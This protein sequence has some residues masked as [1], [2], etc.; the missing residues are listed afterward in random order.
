MIRATSEEYRELHQERLALFGGS[1][2]LISI[3]F[4]V[5]SNLASFLDPAHTFAKWFT[6][7]G[8][9]Y[10]LAQAAVLFSL[11]V[12]SRYRP[13][14]QAALHALD[15]GSLFLVSVFHGLIG[16]AW[17]PEEQYKH[18]LSAPDVPNTMPI[19]T[20]T[21]VIAI[22]RAILVPSTARRTLGVTALASVP[23]IAVSYALNTKASTSTATVLLLTSGAV[24]WTLSGT[25]VAAIASHVVYHLRQQVKNAEKLGQYTL[26]AK[27]GEGA[28]GI[29]YR[30]SHA[31]LRRPTAIKLLPPDRAGEHN[32]ARFE[33]EVQLTSMLT[34]PN[35]IAIYDYGRTPDGIFYYAM[36]YLEGIDLEEL[37]RRH[38]PQPPGRVLRILTQ[39]AG[40]LAEAHGIGLI[41][42]DVKPANIF[43]CERGGVPDVAKIFDFGLVK[44]LSSGGDTKMSAANVLAGTP[45][46]LAPEA[47][48][49]PQ[50]VDARIDLYSLGCVGYFLLTGRPV[51]EGRTLLEICS[52][53]LHEKPVPP[54]ER[55]RGI[56]AKLERVILACLEK[57][58]ARR[59][60]DARAL[61][62]QLTAC[63]DVEAWSEESARR[64]WSDWAPMPAQAEVESSLRVTGHLW[65][66][67]SVPSGELGPVSESVVRPGA[68]KPFPRVAR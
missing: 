65:T 49:T 29:V 4:W 50:T 32:I 21:I 16:L 68:L 55:R 52:R 8:N 66:R 30:A 60:K 13:L 42:R 56:P 5:L 47:I 57:D 15:A 54:S 24:I 25:A 46:Y 53:H 18:G 22:T 6:L 43:L 59:P 41:H 26:E 12:I 39:V 10:H 67:P 23:T 17:L 40:A 38:G 33:R 62:A 48:L 44:Q 14:G 34:H 28:M 37:V 9:R 19:V 36:E 64:F 27:I 61:V 2:F 20:A 1:V 3:G 45:L 58:P 35:T 31:M 11:W 63:D 51:F 7:P